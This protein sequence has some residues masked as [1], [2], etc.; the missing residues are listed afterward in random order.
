[1]IKFLTQLVVLFCL[2]AIAGGA[3]FWY[4]PGIKEKA[5]LHRELLLLERQL[6]EANQEQLKLRNEV[7]RLQNSPKYVEKIIRENYHYSQPD[8][9]IFIFGDPKKTQ[10]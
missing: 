9:M 7:A 10:K 1:M 5:R 2:L 8:E 3:S 4:A 6:D